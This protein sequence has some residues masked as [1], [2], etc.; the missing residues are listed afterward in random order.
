MSV[1]HPR[2][3]AR[4]LVHL[5]ASVALITASWW[6]G[7]CAGAQ[8]VQSRRV[9]TVDGADIRFSHVSLETPPGT[10]TRILQDDQGFLW[11]GTTHGLVRYDGYQ[12]RVFVHDPADPNSLSGVSVAALI[13]DRTGNLWIGSE[14]HLDRYSPAS[15][16]FAHF[17]SD[18]QQACGS[19]V[20]RDIIQD[21]DGIIWVATDNGLKRLD[22]TTSNVNCYQHRHYDDLSIGSN[23]VK[24]MLESQDGTFW[25]ATIEGLDRFDRRTGRVTR[26]VTL[27]GPSGA[28]LKLDGNKISL[29]EDHAGILW[30]TIPGNQGCGLASFDPRTGIQS[31]YSFGAPDDIFSILD[32]QNDMLWFGDGQQGI[33][34]FDRGRK[35][36]TRYRNNPNDLNSVSSTG[37]YALL[38]D[39]EHRIWVGT[40]EGGIDRFDP[41]PETFRTYHHEPGKPNSLSIGAVYSVIQDA[42]GILWLGGAGGLDRID[43]KTGDVTQFMPKQVSSQSAFGVVS[44]IAEDHGGYVWFGNSGNGLARFDSRTGDLKFYRHDPDSPTSLS[45]DNI[46]SLFVDHAG[47]LWV[48][49]YDALNCFDPE[50]EQFQKFTSTPRESLQF[51]AI[52]EDANGALWLASPG[53]G[54]YSFDPKT[55]QFTSYRN[56]PADARTLSND[57]VNAVYVDHAGAIWAGTNSGLSRFDPSSKKFTTYYVR[58]GIA[59]SVVKGILEDRLGDLWLS[60]SDGLSRFN[61]RTNAFKNYYSS[62]GLPGNEFVQGAAFRSSTGEMFFGSTKGLLAFFAEGVIDDSS[63]PP[64]VLTD[65]WLFGDRSGAGKDLLKQSISFVRSL[66]LTPR[67]NIF[68]IEFSALSYSDPARNRYRYKLEGLEKQWNERDSTRRLVTYTTLAPGDYVFRV[69]GSNSLGVWNDTGATVRIRVLGAWWTWWWVRTAFIAMLVMLVWGLHRRRLRQ[70]AHEFNIRLEARVNERTR[71]A[72]DLHDT[73]LQSFQGVLLKFSTIKYMMHSRPEEAEE[74][75]ER[76][77][78]QARDA[79]TEGRDA[80]QGLRSSTIVANDLARAVSTF[81]GELAADQPQQNCPEFRVQVEGESRDLPP[82]VRDEVY[83]IACES[84]RNAFRHAQA[85]RIEVEFRYDSRQFRLRVVDNGKGID[86]EVLTAGGRAG[87][88]GLPGLNERAQLAGGKLSVRSQLKSGTEMELT[89]PAAI[90]Y[91]KSSASRSTSAGTGK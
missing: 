59:S 91:P 15:G 41:R 27:R 30:M 37:I 38:Q 57:G 17:L 72:R 87:H 33:I 44:A 53:Y 82:L 19:G 66:T 61:P 88:H 79:I 69:Q 7:I 70:I 78:G 80:V 26:R 73:L 56:T 32:D 81:A 49:A 20:V 54:L 8:P 52:T 36:A 4:R 68:S 46:G 89:I 63:P 45:N 29:L 31:A 86:P 55:A 5:T 10:I 40:I 16:N 13:K 58:D 3:V 24:S 64:V 60:T 9:P 43:Q 1:Q 25:V 22:P 74:T 90:A 14:Q 2:S 50:T 48:G 83:R 67:Q 85:K 23:L 39:R 42:R 28:L 51:G 12:V 35:T 21:R 62:D 6:S 34:K 11:F 71:I 84:V 75:L 18:S 65:F 47:K 76:L 77:L